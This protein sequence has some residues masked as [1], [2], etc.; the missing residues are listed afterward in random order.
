MRSSHQVYGARKIRGCTIID[1]PPFFES[2]GRGESAELMNRDTTGEGSVPDPEERDPPIFWGDNQGPVVMFWDGML[3]GER[4]SA[5]KIITEEN[6]WII[7]RVKPS[8]GALGERVGADR[9]SQ[10]TTDFLEQHGI[11]SEGTKPKGK[12]AQRTSENVSRGGFTRRKGWYH[13]ND[14]RTMACSRD[15]EIWVPKSGKSYSPESIE[16]IWEA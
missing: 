14:I 7:W 2:A 1:A 6:D 8:R 9:Q 16:E 13:T 4:E 12:K 10:E 15:M 3:P 5:K 11:R